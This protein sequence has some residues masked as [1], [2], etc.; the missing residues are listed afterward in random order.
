M[1]RH[2]RNPAIAMLVFAIG[3]IALVFI[4]LGNGR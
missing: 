3:W 1:S 4:C 2:D